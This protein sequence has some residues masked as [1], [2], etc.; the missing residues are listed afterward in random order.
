MVA[1]VRELEEF[2]FSLALAVI[3]D[4]TI[5]RLVLLPAVMKSAGSRA[6][7]W[8]PGFLKKILPEVRVD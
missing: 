1:E 3:L 8:L 5:M 6:N 2:G 7:W 4:A